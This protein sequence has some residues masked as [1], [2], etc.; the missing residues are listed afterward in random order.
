MTIKGLGVFFNILNVL[1]T[2]Q[3]NCTGVVVRWEVGVEGSKRWKLAVT[4]WQF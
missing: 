3:V 2:F 1:M 4:R